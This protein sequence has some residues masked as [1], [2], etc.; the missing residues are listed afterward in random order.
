MKLTLMMYL[1]T[2]PPEVDGSYFE[3]VSNFLSLDVPYEVQQTTVEFISKLHTAIDNFT[4]LQTEPV[5]TNMRIHYNLE[6]KQEVIISVGATDMDWYRTDAVH[7]QEL[8]DFF[9]V[10]YRWLAAY[11]ITLEEIRSNEIDVEFFPESCVYLGIPVN[12]P[13]FKHLYD[14]GTLFTESL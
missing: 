14:T 9:E 11:N 7:R 2:L 3:D 8:K 5:M 1:L 4:P 12:Y 6:N 10:F 13:E